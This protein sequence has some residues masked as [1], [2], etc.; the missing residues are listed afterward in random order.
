MATLAPADVFK[1]WAVD[2]VVYGPVDPS[3][4]IQWA[5]ENRVHSDTWVHTESKNSWLRA[6][7]LTWLSEHL[8]T[9]AGS[10]TG[11]GSQEPLARGPKEELV[12]P[13]ELR[14]FSVFAALSNDDLSRFTEFAELVNVRAEE[15][16]LRKGAPCD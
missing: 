5:E 4:L 10:G 3:T 9:G 11:A 1:V 12:S 14:Q 2:N 16:I 13:D 15:V 7:D 6:R 8:H